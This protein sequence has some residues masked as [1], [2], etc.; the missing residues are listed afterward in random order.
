MT[1]IFFGT[2]TA[3]AVSTTT[4]LACTPEDVQSRQ[5]ALVT[6]V[7][8][9]VATDPAKAQTIVLKMQEDMAVAEQNN[10]DAAVCV[11]MDTAL[12]AATE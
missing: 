7:Q 3:L 2:L 4:A 11:I 6:A 8:A 12:A 1:H 5:D 9:L 10:D